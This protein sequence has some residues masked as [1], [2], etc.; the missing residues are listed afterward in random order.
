MNSPPT[1]PS[2]ARLRLLRESW[3]VGL[4]AAWAVGVCAIWAVRLL[5]TV[6]RALG[7]R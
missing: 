7:L 1:E 6:A 3:A 5:P 4:A 2:T